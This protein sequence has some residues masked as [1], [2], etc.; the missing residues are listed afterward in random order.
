MLLLVVVVVLLRQ[1]VVVLD[2]CCGVADCWVFKCLF[3]G[4]LDAGC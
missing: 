2:R 4:S 1:T 3:C